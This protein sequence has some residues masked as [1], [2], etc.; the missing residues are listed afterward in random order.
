MTSPTEKRDAVLVRIVVSEKR[1]A[2]RKMVWANHI[3]R[4]GILGIV[5]RRIQGLHVSFSRTDEV[6]E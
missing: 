4:P 6:G 1:F 3:A 5:K 2:V